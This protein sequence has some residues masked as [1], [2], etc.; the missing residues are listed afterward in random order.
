VPQLIG[1]LFPLLRACHF[2]RERD[3]FYMPLKA[4]ILEFLFLEHAF[5]KKTNSANLLLRAYLKR[6]DMLLIYLKC[7]IYFG[8][9]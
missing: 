7:G 5:I 6:M 4:K 2:I 1:T 3:S 8:H 9:F